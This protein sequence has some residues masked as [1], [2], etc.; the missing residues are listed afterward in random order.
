MHIPHS[1][2]LFFQHHLP[3]FFASSDIRAE[4][5]QM[6][7]RFNQTPSLHTVELCFVYLHDLAA[8]A[9][10]LSPI[11]LIHSNVSLC[12]TLYHIRLLENMLYNTLL[13]LIVQ[14]IIP[15]YEL[16]NNEALAQMVI[17]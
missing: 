4:R 8:S 1:F 12:W 11:S 14:L 10:R 5:L 7:S 16:R 2:S 13:K 6:S 3:S 15:M 9:R 17:K